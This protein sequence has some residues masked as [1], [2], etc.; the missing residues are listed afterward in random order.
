MA[1]QLQIFVQALSRLLGWIYT[2]C[3]SASFY[4]QPINNYR[5][6]STTG[7]AI[8]FPTINVL[9]FVCYTIYTSAFLYSPVIRHQYAARHPLAEEPT[10]RFNDF[11]FALHAVVLSFI[12]YTQF[13]PFIWGFKVSRFQK[14]SKPVAGL[15]WG[16]IVAVIVVVFI[17]LAKSPDKGYEPSSWAWIDVI[18]TLSYVKLVITIVKYVPQA[19]VNYKRKSTYGWSISQ[20]LFDLTGGVLSL[21]QL[22]LDSGF[23]NDWS[24]IAGNPIKFLLSNVTI[25]FDLIFVVQHY[26]LY[27]D[28]DDE[29]GK[30]QNPTDRTPLLPEAN[31]LPREVGV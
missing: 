6:R 15:F 4:P 8:D 28:A 9:G 14:V 13:W 27:K 2:L 24:G 10:V 16:S 23:Q 5:R 12:T 22:L 19:W 31:D 1:T 11:A 20:I 7:L 26:V 3:W 29:E 21:A 30:D 17:V 25:F 18:Y